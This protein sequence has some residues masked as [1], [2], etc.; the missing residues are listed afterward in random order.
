M[1]HDE[2]GDIEPTEEMIKAGVDT[3]LLGWESSEADTAVYAIFR[4]MYRVM[5]RQ[6]R[7]R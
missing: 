6:E 3:F 2:D 5:K 4:A 1:T 7:E